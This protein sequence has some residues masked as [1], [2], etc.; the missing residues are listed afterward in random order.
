LEFVLV[1]LGRIL[2]VDDDPDIQDLL[3]AWLR[4][5]GFETVAAW[6]GEQALTLL[7][8]STFDLALVDYRM[9]KRDGL[10]VLRHI[11][12]HTIPVGPLLLTATNNVDLVVEAMRWGALDC[13]I[14]PTPAPSLLIHLDA[15]LELLWARQLNLPQLPPLCPSQAYP[16]LSGAARSPFHA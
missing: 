7:G 1:S 13:L 16:D 4:P 12:E 3:E 5:A 2:L 15:A 9:P 11:A 10:E 14:K 8:E 6:D